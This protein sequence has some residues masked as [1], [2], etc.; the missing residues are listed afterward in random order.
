VEMS[1]SGRP[2]KIADTG[3]PVKEVFA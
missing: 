1:P 3:V 2:F